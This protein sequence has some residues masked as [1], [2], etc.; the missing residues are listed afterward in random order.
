LAR[1]R[2]ALT[3]PRS[4]RAARRLTAAATAVATAAA[5]AA[6][7]RCALGCFVSRAAHVLRR[8]P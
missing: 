8:K 2:G 1:A 6:T 7:A 5:A 3:M 4:C